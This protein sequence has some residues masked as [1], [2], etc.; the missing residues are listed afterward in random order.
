MGYYYHCLGILSLCGMDQTQLVVPCHYEGMCMC[1]H[2]WLHLYLRFIKPHQWRLG[3]SEKSIFHSFRCIALCQSWAAF[4]EN[5]LG[6]NLQ[7]FSAMNIQNIQNPEL[8]PQAGVL[9]FGNQWWRHYVSK[10]HHC[11]PKM[12]FYS[13]QIC[14]TLFKLEIVWHCSA[15]K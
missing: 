2:A 7:A 13:L 4:S 1:S 15:F 3:Q 5:E 9:I 10:E 6:K 11:S 12:S 14:K 8:M